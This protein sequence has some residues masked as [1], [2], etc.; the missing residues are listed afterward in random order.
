MKSIAILTGSFSNPEA[1]NKMIKDQNPDFASSDEDF[2]KSIQMVVD[3]E[4]AAALP[5]RRRRR[6]KKQQQ[7]IQ[8]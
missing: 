5:K 4:N 1:A 7:Q 6:I 2:E 3:S 8:E